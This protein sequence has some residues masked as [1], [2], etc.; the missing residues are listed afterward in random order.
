MIGLAT[1]LLLFPLVL[2]SIHSTQLERSDYE[3]YEEDG[4]S[5]VLVYQEETTYYFDKAAISN[6]NSLQIYTAEQ[7]ILKTDSI[8]LKRTSFFHVDIIP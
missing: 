1:I 5:Y 7:K 8:V 4:V 2:V 6:N 3:V